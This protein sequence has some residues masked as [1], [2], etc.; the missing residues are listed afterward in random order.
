MGMWWTDGR[1]MQGSLGS[2]LATPSA[3]RSD[4][5]YAPTPTTG[6]TAPAHDK[7]ASTVIIGL[8]NEIAGDDGVGIRAAQKLRRQLRNRHDVDVVE[9]PW[10]G[11][12]LLTALRG[13]REAILLDCL[14]SRKH[15]P[16]TVVR[17]SEDDFAGSVRL[18][19]FHDLNYPT[20]L[21]F[22]R[23][24]GWP[25]PSN[26]EIYAVEGGSC[27]RFT[28]CLTPAVEEGLRELVRLVTSRLRVLCAPGP[29]EEV[30]VM[31]ARCLQP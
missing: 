11:L 29:C 16:G 19:S 26:V 12:R 31:R 18:N 14:Q 25:M 24:L 6:E 15:P 5:G 2:T 13:Y 30:E 1:F 22:G 28:S 23:A 9:L 7:D 21:A 27:D 4:G 17:L 3:A 10:A 20:A 8:G